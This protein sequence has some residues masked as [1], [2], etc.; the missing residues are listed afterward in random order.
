MAMGNVNGDVFG[1]QT[2]RGQCIYCGPVWGFD[3]QRNGSVDPF[4]MHVANKLEVV[5]VK[6][7]H[8]VE[9]VVLGHP[10]T[11][12]FIDDCFHVGWHHRKPKLAASQFDASVAL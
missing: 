7:V 1:H 6:S 4:G 11:N 8:D 2:G 10:Q 9:I 12:R 3:A 5:Q